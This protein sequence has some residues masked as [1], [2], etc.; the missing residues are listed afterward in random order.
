M[1]TKATNI[2]GIITE[3]GCQYGVSIGKEA[4]SALPAADLD[5]PVHVVD[6]EAG[7]VS[8]AEALRN[9]DIIGFD[10]ETRPSFRRGERHTVAL[11]QL[12]T[13]TD[14]FLIRLNKIGLPESIRSILEDPAKLKIGLSVKD[15]F[16]SL[17]KKFELTP[18]GFIDLQLFVK[19]FA[20]IDNSLSR[21]YAIL[22]NERISKGQ[23]L[24]NWEA[25][26]LTTH[27]QNYAALDA[28]A[29]ITIYDKLSTEGFS[30]KDSP[31]YKLLYDPSAEEENDKKS[32]S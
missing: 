30:P 17:H 27:Q 1:E 14:C 22:F 15:D 29:C 26:T 13:R 10:T 8:A 7:V 11:M 23:R 12:S 4:L 25:E 6:T 28:R 20:I 9:A 19:Q 3:G 16:N 18:A 24:T 31:H 21:I 32:E 5:L 2:S